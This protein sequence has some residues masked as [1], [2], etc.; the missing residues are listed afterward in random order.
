MLRLQLALA[1]DHSSSAQHEKALGK[2]KIG[3]AF[4]SCDEHHCMGRGIFS[5]L[6]MLSEA[7]PSLAKKRR[8]EGPLLPRANSTRK[9]KLLRLHH[10]Q[11]FGDALH[12]DDGQLTQSRI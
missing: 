10:G 1:S 7:A 6:V 3:L 8:V 4:V 5:N 12:R 2:C 9:T 11:S